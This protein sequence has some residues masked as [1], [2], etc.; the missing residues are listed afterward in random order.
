MEL[1]DRIYVAGANGM[2]GSS[3]VRFLLG[4]GYDNVIAPSHKDLELT[5]AEAVDCFFAEER[6]RYIFDAA[7][8]VGGIKANSEQ[9]ADFLM[10]NILIQNNLIQ[11]SVKYE[12]EKFLFLASSCIYPKHSEQPIKEE[13]LL[14]G[15]LEPTNEG[16]A[17]AKIVGLKLCEYYKS[18]YGLDFITAM[19]ANAYGIN[20][21][22]DVNNSHV[23]P[24]LIK[25]FDDAKKQ[26]LPYVVMWGS[27]N[28]LREFLYVDDL[29]EACVFLMNNYSGRTFINVGSGC[30]VS[31]KQL[32]DIVKAVVGYEGEIRYDISKPDGMPRR[33]VDSS[34]INAMGW[35]A[36]TALEEG[37]KKEYLWYLENA[38]Q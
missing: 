27:G 21:C 1:H 29:A 15:A 20:D 31:M 35:R 24:A 28:A 38:E 5:D 16:Y 11:A 13:A 8:K 37:I 18:Q 26:G 17:L 33:I 25:K 3:I 6:P 14:T 34:R 12:A 22:F 4:A 36:G 19:P 32:A 7:A 10:Q 9:P 30:E 23:I 2:V